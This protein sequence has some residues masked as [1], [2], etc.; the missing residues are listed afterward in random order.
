[1]NV[2]FIGGTGKISSACSQLA[3]DQG[4]ELYLMNR[5]QTLER[6]APNEAKILLG[7]IYDRTSTE[8]AIGDLTFDSVVNWIAYT[9][10]DIENDLA[11]FTGRTEQYIFISS[12]SAYQKPLL[13]LPITEATP[14]L[15]PFWEYS[16]NKIACE[17]RLMREY[18]EEKFPVTIVRPSHTYDKTMI[19]LK[20]GYTAI[21]RIRKGKKVIVHGDGSSLWVLTHHKD[22]A[23]GFIGLLGNSRTIG[24]AFQI[25]SD[26]L[27]SWN[28]IY[29]IM[30]N[31]AGTE[32]K[33]IHIPS[34]LIAAYDKQWGEEL[35]G[36]KSTS[37][38]FDNSKIKSVVPD[39]NAT[40]PFV[41]G[42]K[43]IMNWY[44]ADPSRQIINEVFNNLSDKIISA[45][46]SAFPK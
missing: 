23:K 24:E 38:V 32:A 43:E 10:K 6:P 35:F 29:N 41:N 13:K 5:G 25:T 30:A 34:D 14:L 9:P 1:M 44:N 28:Q 33:I 20:G 42:A 15:N 36:D 46:E 3:V 11:V 40:I 45:Y 16:R 8:N 4:I 22:F 12:A 18:V 7:D 17:E 27:L 37:V 19:P 26:E 21:D 39:F 2:L 31:A